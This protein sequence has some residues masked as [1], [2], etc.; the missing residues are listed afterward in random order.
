[1]SSLEPFLKIAVV[2]ANF[3]RLGC[4]PVVKDRL[5]FTSKCELII[6]TN[7]CSTKTGILLGPYDFEDFSDK[8]RALIS[9]LEQGANVKLLSIRFLRKSIK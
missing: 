3:R 6:S 7:K 8:I 2:F 5:K 9:S 1:M 4:L